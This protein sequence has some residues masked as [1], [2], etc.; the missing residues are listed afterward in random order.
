M[1]NPLNF[2]FRDKFQF[3]SPKKNYFSFL[4]KFFFDIKKSYLLMSK[5]ERVGALFFS[6]MALILLSYKLYDLYIAITKTIPA[7]GG[8]YEEAVV[9]D[10]KYLN[11]ITA[12][13]D[14]DHAVSKLLFSSLVS[15]SGQD[16]ISP[17]LAE[18]WETSTDGMTY[19]FH[20]KKNLKFSDGSDLTASDVAFTVNSIKD[21]AN[22]SP[23]LNS[24]A[25][26]TVNVVDDSTVSFSLP[27]VY[28]P[29]IYNCT[30]G[31]L[32]SGLSSDQFARSVTGDGPYKF[33]KTV[34]AADTTKISSIELVRNDNYAGAAPYIDRLKLD[35]Y[36]NPGDA[37]TAYQNDKVVN[38]LFGAGSSVGQNLSY[39]S[40]R[41][42]GL[43]ANV[44]SDK[45]KD[46]PTRQQFFSGTPPAGGFATPA[47]FN[48]I[49][50]D[51]DYQHTQAEALKTKYAGLNVTLNIQYL[52]ALQMPSAIQGRKYDLI[53]YGFDFGYDR[54]PYAYWHSSQIASGM[55]FAGWSDKNSDIMLEDARMMLDPV[56]RNA[57]YDNFFKT[58]V[59]PQSLAQFFDPIEYNFSVK[60]AVQNVGKISG[61]QVYSRY[62]DISSWYIKTRRVRK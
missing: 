56:A 20:L 25:D 13:S 24:W 33:S 18:S 45:M 62:N 44:A 2:K 19:T 35:F 40:A 38:A 10:L 48:L 3:L 59:T 37:V 29:F 1:K 4:S 16:K 23:L 17:D 46:L 52:S 55:N 14:A 22:K 50:L 31:I 42:L 6:L 15:V 51:S 30:F 57:S 7:T 27:K 32:P 47:S 43:I 60:D 8:T 11:P 36:S 61:N 54:D 41:Q 58:V 12:E 26:V 49:T 21:P 28:G 9:G 34:K 39:Q 5:I 53:L